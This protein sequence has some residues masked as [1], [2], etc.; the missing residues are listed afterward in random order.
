MH[1]NRE[2]LHRWARPTGVA[3]A[4]VIAGRTSAQTPIDQPNFDWAGRIPAG[5][6]LH[7][8]DADGDIRVAA[9]SGDNAKVHGE[10]VHVM[11]GRRALVFQVT[12]SGQDV[13]V[14]A[15]HRGGSCDA[16]GVHEDQGFHIFTFGSDGSANFTVE[17]PAGVNVALHSGDGDVDVTGT[18]G[19]VSATSGD[20]DIK[21]GKVTGSVEAS[22][23]DGAVTLEDVSGSIKAHSGDGSIKVSGATGRVDATTGDGEI[24]VALASGSANADVRVH[25]GD[26]SVTVGLPASF[27]GQ[28]SASTGDGT[29]ESDFPVEL[30]GRIDHQH[31]QSTLGGGGPARV[32]IST[33][34]GNIHLEKVS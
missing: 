15:F 34:D 11:S 9:A 12:T 23:G 30:T 27:K 25:T 21:I 10:R 17:L 5:A 14:C 22:S 13:T 18:T 16:T 4:L 7:I 8:I 26:G 28:F 2:L 24:D 19:A 20:G 29:V 31:I 32:D 1:A 6:T 3:L 33:G